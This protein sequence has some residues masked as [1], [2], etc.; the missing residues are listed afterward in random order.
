MARWYVTLMEEYPIYEPAE[1]GYY[2][3]G[4][5]I[6]DV[7]EFN[8]W[9]KARQF[10]NKVRK[11]FI[12]EFGEPSEVCMPRHNYHARVWES[13]NH[14]AIFHETDYVGEGHELTITRKPRKER[15]WVPYE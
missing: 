15:G 6:T 13:R 11:E 8:T 5:S 10:Y 12:A 4:T 2:Y 3:A 1:G 7:R 14:K 9:R